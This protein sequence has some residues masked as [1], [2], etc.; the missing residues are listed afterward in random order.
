MFAISS[1]PSAPCFIMI[2]ALHLAPRPQE[3]RALLTLNNYE[4][5]LG[6]GLL[7]PSAAFRP[8][9]MITRQG[10]SCTSTF[11]FMQSILIPQ[12]PL[13]KKIGHPKLPLLPELQCIVPF[14]YF[15]S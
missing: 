11:I 7:H 6:V 15:E 14:I 9:P 13:S 2:L 4:I 1:L 10:P 8:Q 5:D 3:T 12:C